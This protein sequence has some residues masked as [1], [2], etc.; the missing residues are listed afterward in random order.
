ML[1][2]VVAFL[3]V[4]GVVVTAAPRAPGGVGLSLAGVYLY[5]WGSGY[6]EPSTGILAVLT[7]LALLTLASKL[8]RPVVIARVGGTPA[9][10]TTIGGAVGA[11][12]FFV[13]GTA[14]LVIGIF[15]T[16]FVLEYL[17]RGNLTKSA[18]ASVVVVLATFTSKLVKVLVALIILVVMSA[19]VLL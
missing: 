10:T 2:A 17:R 7:T 16:V 5:W 13:W 9:I 12:L 19:V 6:S 4:A 1:T 18:I 14:G 15:A 3:L 8:I 11:V